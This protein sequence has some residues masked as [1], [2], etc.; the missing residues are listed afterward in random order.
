MAKKY[1]FS[2]WA[3][4]NNIKCSDGRVIL[5][6]AFKHHDGQTVPLVWNHNHK[7]AET[8]LGH[9]LLE[10]RD[11]GVYAYCSFNDTP[12]GI[13]AK[14]LVKHGDIKA[15]SIYANQLKQNSLKHV[16]HGA[17]REVSLVLAGAN[18]GAY[19]ETI[20]AHSDDID[21]EAK[22]FNPSESLELS[23]ELKHADDDNEDNEDTKDD[24][25]EHQSENDQEDQK[26]MNKKE[27]DENLQHEDNQN[28]GSE[29]TVQD[30]FDSFTDLQKNVVYALIGQALDQQNNNSED[31]EDMKQNAFDQTNQENQGTYVLSHSDVDK[32]FKS[33]QQIGSLKT[34]VEQ[35]LATELK[36][37][38]ENLEHG[39]TDIGNLFPE[40]Q[41]LN[42]VPSV[43][44]RDQE[45]VGKVMNA[46]SKSPFSRVKSTY[47][48]MTEDEA[49]AKGYITGDQKA[50]GVIKALKR[51]TTP[52]T[53]YRLD[54]LDRDDVLDIT[55]FDVIAFMKSK[56]QVLL[57]EEIARAIL[58][59]DGREDVDQYKIK[60]D[61]MRPV[62]GDDPVYTVQRILERAD[63]ATDTVFAKAFIK[64][65]IRAR[66]LYKG[67][68]NPTLFTSEDMLTEMLL[69]EDANG[70]DIYD[71]VEKLA[72]KLRVKEI[73]TVPQMENLVRVN[74]E[75]TFDYTCLGIM[76]NLN[77]YNVGADKGGQQ[78]LFDNFDLN[79][80][81]YEYLIETRSSGALTIPYSAISFEEKTAHEVG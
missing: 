80:N 81:K 1:D 75:E 27:K 16:I 4:R 45:W 73:V 26:S 21:E 50:A 56:M 58:I 65:M 53:I 54:K 15:L 12:Q 44:A 43:V 59:G 77:D 6:D 74:D 24:D 48:D 33:A 42:K 35:F 62:L 69:I 52:Q 38:E 37:G 68:G 63:G 22:I 70:R 51:V 60:T 57:K 19:I 34:A 36:H 3:T 40:V 55:D 31:N 47:V 11:E 18:P 28:N 67:S 64:D 14:K 66:K 8:V 39:I 20:I 5:K 25:L 30:V 79:F 61:N 29:Q 41:S 17:I 78:T 49:R 7:D 76:V 23:E 46:V 72:T 9:A 32:I 13:N 2:G 71:S 10:N